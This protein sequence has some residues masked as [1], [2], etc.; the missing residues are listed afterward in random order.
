MTTAIKDQSISYRRGRPISRQIKAIGALL[1]C[2]APMLLSGSQAINLLQSIQAQGYLKV[3][4]INGP[5]TYYEG[6]FGHMGFE[7][8]LASAFANDIGVELVVEDKAN[9]GD[10]LTAIN[11][12][13]PKAEQDGHFIAAGISV[14]KSRQKTFNFSKPYST[15][16]QQVIY[17][18]GD[19]KPTSVND[20]IGKDIVVISQ[21]SHAENLRRL[22]VDYPGLAWREESNA[23]M[24]D[25][26][27]RV[28]NGQA[29][30]VIVDSTAFITN[31]SI[32]P[33]ARLAVSIS[34]PEDIAWAFPKSND[35]SL[36]NAANRFLTRSQQ[37]GKL[38][39]LE[40]KYF[41]KALVSEGSAL[42]FAKRIEERLPKWINEFK[43]A[44]KAYKFD[45]LFL[46]AVSYQESLWN[47]NAKSYTGV[48]GLMMLTRGTASDLGVKDRTDPYQSIHGGAKY[49]KQVLE[50]IPQNISEPDR[51]WMALASYNVGYGCLLYTSPSPRDRG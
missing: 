14:L 32:Y 20:L 41:D 34:E 12:Q 31:K 2:F 5:S 43:K 50:R 16:T 6:P 30:I 7:Y 18:R 25:L 40:S 37:S 10:M 1:L 36:L 17:R 13:T 11:T 3:L 24:P 9:L 48:R 27:D 19:P 47:E 26:L 4:S 28:H 33:K 42:A 15:V 8:E 22:K 23:E 51:I 49:L 44:G 35:K 45:W 21:S 46:A 38:A 29:E 39:E